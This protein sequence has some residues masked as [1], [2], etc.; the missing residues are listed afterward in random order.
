[1]TLNQ[2]VSGKLEYSSKAYLKDNDLTVPVI[3]AEE[4]MHIPGGRVWIDTAVNAIDG[5]TFNPDT[6]AKI[7]D[8]EEKVKKLLTVT[9]NT[10]HIGKMQVGKTCK[11]GDIL[12]Y[13]AGGYILADNRSVNRADNIVIATCDSNTVTGEV[14][15]SQATTIKTSDTTHDGQCVYL[16]ENGEYVF[17]A[18]TVAGTVIKQIGFFEQNKFIFNG[19][20]YTFINK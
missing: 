7:A 20:G 1:M 4:M 12:S 15:V 3:H 2:G 19:L 16:G 11:M 14:E 5:A 18:P 6:L 13:T 10:N 17:D 8:L 9:S